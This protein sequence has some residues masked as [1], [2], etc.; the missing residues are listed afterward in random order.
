MPRGGFTTPANADTV[1]LYNQGVTGAGGTSTAPGAATIVGAGFGD[2]HNSANVNLTSSG[3]TYNN[4][5]NC[6]HI[7]ENYPIC[8]MYAGATASAK[9]N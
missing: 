7:D 4:V 1:S 5:P 3:V 9:T 8:W 6:A 2:P